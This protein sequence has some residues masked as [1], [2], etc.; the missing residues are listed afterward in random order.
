MSYPP[1]QNRNLLSRHSPGNRLYRSG[2][3]F[4]DPATDLAFPIFF[5][6]ALHFQFLIHGH[7]Q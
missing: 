6:A 2:I 7:R 3:D 5:S 1:K 4:F